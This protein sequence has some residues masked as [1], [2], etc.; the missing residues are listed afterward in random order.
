MICPGR[1]CGQVVLA[2]L[3]KEGG[4]PDIPA[5]ERGLIGAGPRL[6]EVASEADSTPTGLVAGAEPKKG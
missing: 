2:V 3:G 1:A 4:C 5:G 6:T